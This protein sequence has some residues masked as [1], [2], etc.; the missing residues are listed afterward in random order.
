MKKTMDPLIIIPTLNELDNIEILIRKI[1][2]LHP[3]MNILVVDGNSTDGTQEKVQ[4]LTQQHATVH[5]LVQKENTSFGK[6]IVQGFEFALTGSYDPVITM[7]GDNSH[8]PVFIQQFLDLYPENDLIIGSRY[9]DG[10]RVE[11]WQFR[12]LMASKLA[13]IYIS[14][15]LIRPIWDFTSGFRLYSRKLINSL[16]LP[17]LESQAYLLQVQLIFFAYHN[18]LRVK[19]IPIV[20]KDRYPGSSKIATD[21]IFR[22]FVNIW[23]YRAP[24]SE[25]LRHLLYLRKNYRRFTLEYEAFINPPELKPFPVSDSSKLPRVSIGVMAYNE[26]KI[27]RECLQ[28]LVNQQVDNSRVI[29]IIVISSGSTDNTDQ[30]VRELM[31]QDQRIQ[32]ITQPSRYG[33]A[34]AINLFL[35]KAKGDI[36]V[37]ESADTITEPHTIQ[38]LIEPFKD[39]KIG[40]TGAHPIPVN[41]DNTFIGFCVHKLWELHHLMALDTPKCGEMIAFRNFIKTIPA[42]TA[43][44]EAVIESIIA[45]AGYKLAYAK[46]AIVKN[47]GP[48]NLKDFIKQRRRIAIGHRHLNVL[49]GHKV[50]TM[51]SGKIWKY[52]LKSKFKSPKEVFYM[53]FLILIEAYVRFMGFFDYQFRDKNPF[54][55][56]I[57]KSTKHMA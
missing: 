1:L 5:L 25:I 54:I 41:S 16:N 45:N 26:E 27:I 12:K 28:A 42:Y 56:D 11:G 49:M 6:A 17:V 46:D 55:W 9:I 48:E 35:E 4:N 50:A 53:L 47:K 7:D 22:T 10:I 23:K 14:Y 33:K 37:I 21:S 36:V 18:W 3:G 13:N 19:E 8:D 40:M 2:K 24:L 31:E 43:V 57:S 30:I 15:I 51:N 38:A 52:V 44:D 39:P 34:S 29:E 32:L 20:F